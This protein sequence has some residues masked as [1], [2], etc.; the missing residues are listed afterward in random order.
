MQNIMVNLEEYL[1][2]HANTV[3]WCG[4]P[5]YKWELNESIKI[6]SIDLLLWIWNPP[7]NPSTQM[8][9]KDVSPIC[10]EVAQK[11]NS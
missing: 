1:R 8:S 4:I 6:S 11:D 3:A 10:S 9:L 7:P 2:V 5:K